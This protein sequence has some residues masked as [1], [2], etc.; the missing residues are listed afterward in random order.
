MALHPGSKRGH[1]AGDGGTHGNWH[2]ISAA[3]ALKAL[4]ADAEAGL[5]HDEAS[6]RLAEH[7]PNTLPEAGH[8]SMWRVFAGQFASPLIYILFAAAIIAFAMETAQR[9][10]RHPRRGS[11][12]CDH[13]RRA[14]RPGG[15][16]DGIAA[17]AFRASRCACVRDGREEIIEARDLVRGDIVLLAAGDAVAADARLL[18]VRRAR[19]GGGGAHGGVGAGGEASRSAS[20]GHGTRGPQEHDLFRHAR[21]G[22]A[23][24]VRS[25]SPPAR[26][27][28]SARSRADFCPPWSRRPRSNGASRSLAVI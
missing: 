24:H 22:G 8:R 9:C 4:S 3:D 17:T 26:T 6:R 23:R 20:G 1:P 11:H 16:F 7:G 12:Q 14:G 19:G 27:A 5:S 2:L 21:H 28:R 10:G 13:R 25:S 18:R 15:A